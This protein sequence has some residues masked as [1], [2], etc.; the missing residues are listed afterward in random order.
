LT[1]VLHYLHAFHR[2][3]GEHSSP[4]DKFSRTFSREW[5]TSNGKL[6]PRVE[7]SIERERAFIIT[8][9]HISILY[10]RLEVRVELMS[11]LQY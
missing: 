9:Q 2:K 6:K 7:K 10:P 4:F 8:K 1:I 3:L 11:L 5:F